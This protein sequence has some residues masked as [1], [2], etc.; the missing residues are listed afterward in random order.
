MP[1]RQGGERG[2]LCSDSMGGLT[3]SS[4][5]LK[6]LQAREPRLLI[7]LSPGPG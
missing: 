3:V 1:L 2:P 7:P 4:H 5:I 6:Y